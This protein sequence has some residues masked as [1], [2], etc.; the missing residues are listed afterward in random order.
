MNDCFF[1]LGVPHYPI[2][3]L[4]GRKPV[5][6]EAGLTS[7]ARIYQEDIESILGQAHPGMLFLTHVHYDHC[8]A[9]AYLKQAFPGL[10][11]A[12]SK[13]AG[14]IIRR[15][16]AIELIRSLNQ[17]AAEAVAHLDESRLLK[18]SF[19]PFEIDLVLEDGQVIMLEEDVS[20]Q[21]LS[22]PGHTWDFLSY[23]VPEHKLL[24]ASEAIGCANTCGYIITD[25]LVDFDAYLNS[26]KRLAGLDVE[27]LCQGHN[28]VYVAGDVQ[29]FFRRSI[30]TA[31]DF[32]AMM[33]KFWQVE[34]GDMSRVINSIKGIEYD[35]V[36]LPKQPESAYLIN[37]EARIRSV[38]KNTSSL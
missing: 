15:P 13:R 33:E 32:K 6:F 29:D 14:E 16:S 28:F 4:N 26:L 18:E 5:L 9:V 38:L 24:I 2:Y 22:S 35:P 30:Q 37:L 3:L 1:V 17:N 7:L 31:L 11:V 25:C 8:G 19:K 21:V 34:G 27:V 36:P 23:Y 12:A 10:K 20:V